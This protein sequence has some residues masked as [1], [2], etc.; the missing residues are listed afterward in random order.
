MSHLLKDIMTESPE[1]IA[2]EASL[3]NAA[4]TMRDCDTGFLPV[5]SEGSIEGV[6]TDRDIVVRAIADGLDPDETAV[7]DV[8]TEEYHSLLEDQTVDEALDL[9]EAQEVRRV[10]VLD[11]SENIVGV[12]SL[13][14]LAVRTE[15]P[16]DSERVLE[17]VS[18]PKQSKPKP[19]KGDG[20]HRAR[21]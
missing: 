2:P 4:E 11:R 13:G 10:L 3:R 19:P 18:V 15:R 20:A 21:H 16:L 1:T 7:S 12:V 14:D 6:I 17:E 5:V 8:M 9:M